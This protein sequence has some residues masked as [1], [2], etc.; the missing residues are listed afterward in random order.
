MFWND[1]F[2]VW[3]LVGLIDGLLLAR[4]VTCGLLRFCDLFVGLALGFL[5][6]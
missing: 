5:C 1:C 6:M 4:F 3:L 2:G